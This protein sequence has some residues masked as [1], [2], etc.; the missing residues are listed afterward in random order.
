MQPARLRQADFLLVIINKA[1]SMHLAMGSGEE[2]WLLSQTVAGN[3]VVHLSTDCH[4]TV[5][6][7]L[8]NSKLYINQMSTNCTSGPFVVNNS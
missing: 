7:L 8:A 6:C 1:K 4:F 3:F 2:R 5:C